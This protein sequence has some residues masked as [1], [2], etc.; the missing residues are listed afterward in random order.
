MAQVEIKDLKKGSFVTIDGVPCRVDDVS[1]SKSGKHGHAKVRVDAI[2]LF[3][4]IR[5]SIVK[6]SDAR[7][8]TPMILKKK[9]QVL[10]IIGNKAQLMNLED[11]STLEL[12]IPEELQGKLKEGEEIFLFEVD[13]VR[14]LKQIK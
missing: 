3:D 9:A 2:G 8:D 5:K 7:V 10:A 13:G 4:G 6:P 11:Y 12:D 1:I 14:T